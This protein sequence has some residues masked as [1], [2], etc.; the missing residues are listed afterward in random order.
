MLETPGRVPETERR[1][2]LIGHDGPDN[3]PNPADVHA[4]T[5]A[6]SMQAAVH[7]IKDRNYF[8]TRVYGMFPVTLSQSMAMISGAGTDVELKNIAKMYEY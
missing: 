7:E 6:G 3:G 5:A 8:C 1:S 2:G 4:T